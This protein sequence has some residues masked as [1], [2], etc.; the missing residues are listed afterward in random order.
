M[1][2]S[3]ALQGQRLLIDHLDA[4][5]GNLGITQMANIF[6]VDYLVYKFHF[7]CPFGFNKATSY[8]I[9]FLSPE[10]SPSLDD[11]RSKIYSQLC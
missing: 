10:S 4:A 1:E 2:T 7:G 6:F 11:G 5:L 9:R 8:R 3:H